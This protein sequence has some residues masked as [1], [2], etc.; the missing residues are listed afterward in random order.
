[1]EEQ[2]RA[3]W[4]AG[5]AAWPGVVVPEQEF[6]AFVRACHSAKSGPEHPETEIRSADL[7]LACACARGQDAAIAAFEQAYFRDVDHVM[8]KSGGPRVPPVDEVRQLV[9]H[10]IFVAEPGGQPKIAEYSGRGDLRS[11]FRVTVT[12]MVLNLSSRGG[13]EVPFEDD[14]LALM[15]GPADAAPEYSKG[16]Y[17]DEFRAAFE[18]AFAALSD[19]DRSLLRYAFGEE[20]TVDAIGALHSVHRATAA[21]WVVRAHRTLLEGVRSLLMARLG[22]GED[23]YAS[24]LRGIYSRLDLSLERYLKSP[25]P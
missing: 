14:L 6:I 21:R 23:E 13:R 25:A 16:A 1:M 10:K 7:Y 11:W 3:A 19:R 5:R 12:R 17:K 24:V 9:R 8:K 2:L 18:Q 22:L 4:L 20:L 15:L